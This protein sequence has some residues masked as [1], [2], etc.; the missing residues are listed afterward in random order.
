MKIARDL[1]GP[2]LALGRSVVAIGAF[3]G[4]HLG[5]QAMLRKLVLRAHA[6][7]ATAWVLSFDPLPREFFGEFFGRESILRILPTAE[8]LRQLREFGVD[9]VLLLR[10]NAALSHMQPED[11]IQRA[12]VQRLRALEVWVG[13]DFRFGHKRAGSVHTLQHIGAQ[14]ASSQ[15]FSVHSFAQVD[16]VGARV[17]ASR[18]RAALLAADFT[19]AEALL[20]RPY[21]FSGRVVHGQQ[22]GRTLGFPTANLLWPANA[23][24]MSGI[25]AVQVQTPG[26]G[27]KFQG[28]ASLGTRPTVHGV[29]PWL[30]VHLFD[31]SGDLYGQRI[32]VTFI[33]KL[34]E[35]LKFDSLPDMVQ[36]IKRDA[37]QARAILQHG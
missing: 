17:S 9:G 7:A 33:Q 26:N 14:Q 2:A 29:E 21:Q 24:Q 11:F 20:G 22:L 30:E 6:L 36:Q 13:A 18:V 1:D 31:F 8:K 35:E 25:F 23:A 15:Q 5:H 28:V 3:D 10:F 12:L 16:A 4:L 19:L 34:R 37:A 27:R 32:H